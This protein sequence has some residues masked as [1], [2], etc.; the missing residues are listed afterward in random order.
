MR[1]GF[2]KLIL[3]L[4]VIAI[5]MLSG[6]KQ[7]A[8]AQ[9]KGQGQEPYAVVQDEDRYT[10]VQDEDRYAVVQDEDR[11]AR[12]QEK[13]REQADVQEQAG[14]REQQDVKAEDEKQDEDDTDEYTAVISKTYG[15]ED[16]EIKSM[17]QGMITY[18]SSDENIA[19]V[20]PYDGKVHILKAGEVIITAEDFNPGGYGVEKQK[21]L[22]KIGRAPVLV[23]EIYHFRKTYDGNTYIKREGVGA[24]FEGVLPGD[25]LLLTVEGDFSDAKA[26]T[27]KRVYFS[28]LTLGGL[29]AENYELAPEGQP[30]YSDTGD[31]LQKSVKITGI[32]VADKVYDGT[33]DAVITGTAKIEGLIPGDDVWVK[34]GIAAFGSSDVGYYNVKFH[35][36]H[37]DGPDKNNY[38][39]SG[40]PETSG[41]SIYPRSIDDAAVFLT[42]DRFFYDGKQKRVNI[43]RV[44][45]TEDFVLDPATDY[46]VT[47]DGFGTDKGRYVLTVTGKDNYTGTLRAEWLIS[48]KFIG[49]SAPDQQVIY[50]NKPHSI[51]V[52]V[53]GLKD[54]YEILYGTE[55]GN[56]DLTAS[57][58]IIEAGELTVYY[59]VS[60]PDYLYEC[61]KATIHVQPR[62]VTIKADD[63]SKLVRMSDPALTATVTG[64]IRSA[65]QNSVEYEL[66]R[67]AGEEPG[68]YEIIPSGKILQRNY[69][70]IFEK[71]TF[72]ISER[73][74]DEASGKEAVKDE[75]SV[76][77]KEEEGKEIRV[78]S[79]NRDLAVKQ[80]VDASAYLG[81]HKKYV[82]L[83]KGAAR[84]DR[85]KK[86]I[87]LKKSGMI[88]ITA[89]DKEGR[90]WVPKEEVNLRA[91]QTMVKQKNI[92]TVAMGQTID[93]AA[94][95]DDSVLIPDRWESSNPASVAVDEKTGVISP[96]TAGR[97]SITAYYGSGK[98]AA[99]VKFTIRVLY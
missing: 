11:Y 19:T 30:T 29:S 37:L 65:S 88:T 61:G 43:D 97:A 96:M 27:Q 60:A 95:I 91:Y 35:R 48:D 93:G 74:K 84:I 87:T 62:P 13:N 23:K 31:I 79:F 67:E 22:V 90:D 64:I 14:A 54:G 52:G 4:S 9:E 66:S 41:A 36:Y 33:K 53:E 85:K 8:M 57:P 94:N 49:A 6:G 76:T 80:K 15:D 34:T 46:E 83:P 38:E 10:V 39:L 99:K 70:L 24:S 72:T 47:G 50:D 21:Y 82:V 69:S 12:V 77:T 75:V 28:K 40:Q 55:Y 16:F 63:K 92:K 78:I 18:L 71:G 51:T 98:N 73:K 1:S 5:G 89:Y 59:K 68:T 86:L 25:Q 44:E 81:E 45:L 32:S 42:Q 20:G 3:F 17:A 2:A 26:G 56:Y 58:S 7:Y